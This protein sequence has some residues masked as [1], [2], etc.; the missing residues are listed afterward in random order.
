MGR[1]AGAMGTALRRVTLGLTEEGYEALRL[2][3][4][5]GSVDLRAY[6]AP[7]ARAGVV[8]LG[9]IGGGWDSPARGLYPRLARTLQAQGLSV[10]RVK[11]RHRTDLRH[12]RRDALAALSFLRSTGVE[13]SAVI[14]HSF[15]GAVGIQ[16]AAAEPRVRTVVTLATQS[17]G[18]DPVAQLDGRCAL[19]AVHGT[20]DRTLPPQCSELVY[21]S[22]FDPKR[23][24]LFEGAGHGLDEVADQLE[25]LLQRWLVEWLPRRLPVLPP[26]TPA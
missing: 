20:E 10:V 23:L 25:P 16:A 18:T 22:A 1:V 9:G 14:G 3:T 26:A 4:A 19:L 13:G 6:L 15:G 7:G 24:L 5:E 8:L 2:E 21:M 17:L 11:Y 12:S